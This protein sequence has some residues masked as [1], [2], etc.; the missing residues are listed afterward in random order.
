MKLKLSIITIFF[1][2]L[3]NAQSPTFEWAKNMGGDYETKAYGVAVDNQGNVY[4][5]GKFRDAVDF[6]PGSS[7]YYLTPYG[8][9]DVF[10]QKLDANGNFLWAKKLGEVK[11]ILVFI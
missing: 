8:D 9:I 10:V 7:D 11:L 2:T 3:L 6:D 1:I 5:V 4:T